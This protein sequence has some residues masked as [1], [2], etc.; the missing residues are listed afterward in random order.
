MTLPENEFLGAL[1]WVVDHYKACSA[2]PTEY[3]GEDG[4]LYDITEIQYALYNSVRIP[5]VN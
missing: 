5:E 4:N 2:F 1:E 3:E